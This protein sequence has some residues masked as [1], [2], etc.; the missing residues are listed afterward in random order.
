MIRGLNS[1]LNKHSQDL[2]VS[3]ESPNCVV[4]E[5]KIP[6]RLSTST[7]FEDN[8]ISR[9]LDEKVK[10][11][12]IDYKNDIVCIYPKRMNPE[13]RYAYEKYENIKDITLIGWKFN[14]SK[15]GIL[16]P[17]PRTSSEVLKFLK[18]L[19]S[20]FIKD[21]EYG[22]GFINRYRC[23][24]ESLEKTPYIKHFVISS[25]NQTGIDKDIYSLSI[26]D[27]RDLVRKINRVYRNYRIASREERRKISCDHLMS[28]IDPYY[29]PE[30]TLAK[31]DAISKLVSETNIASLPLSKLDSQ[32]VVDLVSSNIKSIY[33]NQEKDF[34]KLGE[35]IKLLNLK[36]LIEK[37]EALLSKDKSREEEWQKL[38]NDN[39]F[40]LSIVFGYPIEIRGQLSVGGR[41]FSG[42]GDKITDFL[43]KNN[44]TNNTVLIEIKTPGTPLLLSEYRSGVFSPSKEL[45]GSINQVLDQKYMFQKNI[46][47]MKENSDDYSIE[48]YSVECILII[49]KIPKNKHE[50]KSFELFRQNSKDVRIFTFD[51]LFCK[52]KDIHSFLEEINHYPDLND[53]P[54]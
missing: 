25:S 47:A 30:P 8:E 6:Q 48:S 37:M 33:K 5:Y 11:L 17:L 18:R 22:L 7:D 2:I 27:F 54:F 49:G 28:Q 12:R 44:L 10:L 35:D 45:C 13:K 40:M 43:G 21:Y 51:E 50:K 42:S 4:V 15:D 34:V 26:N 14:K 29:S 9:N 36:G 41:K 19:P 1:S 53:L 23:I 16:L 52:L 32:A 20:C 31:K 38:I 39:P 46:S 3:E 24:V